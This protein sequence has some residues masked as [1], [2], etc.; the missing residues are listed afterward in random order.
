[1]DF[2]T[3]P[4][5]K[6]IK[7]FNSSE[8]YGLSAKEASIRLKKYGENALSKSKNKSVF[9][10]ILEALKEPMLIILLFGLIIT[11]GS[12][13]GEL[14]K[15]GRA[16]FTECLG[17]F[18]AILLSVSITLFMEGSSEKAFKT[19]NRFYGDVSVKVIREG[20]VILVSQKNLVVGDIVLIEQGDKIVADGRLIYTNGLKIDESALT[21]ESKEISKNHQKICPKSA[22]LAERVNFVYSGSFVREGNGKMIV[23]ATGDGTE[24]G[25]IAKGLDSKNQSLSP[26]K[27]KLGVLGKTISLVGGIVAGLV[28]VICFIRL[29]LSS[30]LS[31]DGVREL[32]LSCVVLLIATVP[33]GLPT[34][35]AVSLALNMIKLAG[36]N[37]L[38]KK[39]SATETAG[40]VSV[41]C[42][43]KTGTLTQNK[44]TV[45]RI[46]TPVK[47]YSPSELSSKMLLLNFACNTTASITEKGK[48][49]GSSTE[50]AL[51]KA[52]LKSKNALSVEEYRRL[53]PIKDRTP[54]SSDKKYM[55][56]TIKT[57]DGLIE[58][59][60]GAPEVIFALVKT[61][62]SAMIIES[63]EKEKKDAKRVLCFAHKELYGESQEYVFD[64][65]VSILDPIRK[66]VKKA[67]EDCKR[68]GIKI[69]ILTGDSAET[70]FSIAKKLG[71]AS[72]LENVAL[73][74]DL[75]KLSETALIHA[76]EKI[77]VVARSTPSIKLKIVETLKKQGEVVAVT[78]DGVNDAPAIKC[79][80]VG[81][82]MGVSGSE[83][84]KEASDI[85]LLDDSFSSVVSAI[86]FGRAVYQNIRKFITF[87]LSVN[88]SALLFITV[89]VVLGFPPPFNTLE[90]LW[91][92]LIMDGP[93]ALTLGLSKSDNDLMNY[94]PVKK[95]KSIVSKGMLFKIIF[96]AVFVGAI[97]LLQL[98][99]NIL[100]ANNAE[101]S[102][103]IFSL[104]VFFQL[105]NAFCAQELGLNSVIKSASKNKIMLLTFLLVFVLHLV[106]VEV[107]YSVFS[108]ARIRFIVLV[109]AVILA[110]SV[111]F[112][113]EIF[114]FLVRKFKKRV[115][116]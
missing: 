86:S 76:L 30:G 57:S 49:V 59:I 56:T 44:M 20:R 52:L 113:T 6:T 46:F 70:A 66:D 97:M 91:I 16:D 41:I 26:L 93:P 17:I 51:I 27:N 11:L 67:V 105:F 99:F 40:A 110:S 1:M 75:E 50:G 112:A 7:H 3:L 55:S 47:S 31:F 109:R 114:N 90:L 37:A 82:A 39:M 54:F 77:T 8:N 73:S 80:D 58:L 48:I 85:V 25:V 23:T 53:Y 102:S 24:L 101:K 74:S 111:V 84:T 88:F 33:E 96:S 45:E 69:K 5:E 108:F 94:K 18:I 4:L 22:P 15:T 62:V 78:G 65:F 63:L 83:I 72:K 98:F 106:M 103:A 13:I 10:K 92:N 64:G 32:F 38:I 87:Q 79:A 42:S 9:S 107:L 34:I 43:D 35:V 100:G 12:C 71:V 60:K 115:K 68:A 61:G 95:D 28:F 81:I 2:Y 116:N 14:L 29:T 104:F 21:G 19:L 36:K 89:C